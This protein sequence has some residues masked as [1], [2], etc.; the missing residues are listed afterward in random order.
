MGTLTSNDKVIHN[1]NFINQRAGKKEIVFE[2]TIYINYTN[3]VATVPR[4]KKAWVVLS[5]VDDRLEIDVNKGKEYHKHELM[6][7]NAPDKI[8]ELT[9]HVGLNEVE[10]ELYNGPER[11]VLIGEL[12]VGDDLATAHEVAEWDI[13]DLRAAHDRIVFGDIYRFYID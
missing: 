2:E 4:G 5:E 7:H 11:A 3:G 9:T 8:L 1:W 13:R 10:I 6:R 12:K